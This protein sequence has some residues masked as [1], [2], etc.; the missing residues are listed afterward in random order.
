MVCRVDG[1]QLKRNCTHCINGSSRHTCREQWE[2]GSR[3]HDVRLALQRG[4]P[5]PSTPSGE[6]GVGLS[7]VSTAWTK[8]RRGTLE[9]TGG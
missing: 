1:N 4:S 9:S 5:W 2:T 6:A 7:G 3:S 8:Q